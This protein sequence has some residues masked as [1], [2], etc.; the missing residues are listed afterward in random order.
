[1]AGSTIIEFDN[2]QG[3]H[4]KSEWGVKQELYAHIVIITLSRIFASQI[5]HDR[6]LD[7]AKQ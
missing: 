6:K 2:V 3:F 7:T 4:S 1:L 5:E